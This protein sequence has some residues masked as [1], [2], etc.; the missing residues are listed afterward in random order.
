MN[1]SFWNVSSRF[2]TKDSD[3]LYFHPPRLF[4][5]QNFH[6]VFKASPLACPSGTKKAPIWYGKKPPETD[7][8]SFSCFKFARNPRGKAL[9]KS[10]AAQSNCSVLFCSVLFCSVLFC[11]VRS[12]CHAGFSVNFSLQLS[13][14]REQYH[15]YPIL[16]FLSFFLCRIAWYFLSLVFHC[17]YHVPVHC[18]TTILFVSILF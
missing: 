6:L 2:F 12:I 9:P 1:G 17:F 15:L 13:L 7:A 8:I 16:L 10:A 5:N 11:S 18:N 14:L 3:F 4:P